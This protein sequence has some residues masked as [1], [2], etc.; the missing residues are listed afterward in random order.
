[1]LIL[2][3]KSLSN[4]VLRVVIFWGLA[5]LKFAYFAGYHGNNPVFCPY[6]EIL[7]EV[8]CVRDPPQVFY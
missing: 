6:S 3:V 8:W 1:M 4:I 7:D 5:M 2:Y